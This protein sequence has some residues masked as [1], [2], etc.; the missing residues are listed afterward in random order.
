MTSPLVWVS[1]LKVVIITVVRVLIALL[2][3]AVTALAVGEWLGWSFLR[4]PMET[5]LQDKLQ[6]PVRLAE[7]FKLQLLGKVRL[8]VGGLWIAA[9]KGF[10]VPYLVDAKELTL[11]LAYDDIWDFTHH[12][13]LHIPVL[14]VN[15]IAVQLVRHADGQ[16]TWQFS[17]NR[18]KAK[19]PALPIIDTLQLRQGT[20]LLR[21]PITQTDIN[22]SFETEEGAA[23]RAPVSR[24]KAKGMLRQYAIAG[25]ITTAGFLSVVNAKENTLLKSLGWV[26]YGGVRVDFDGMLSDL[27]GKLNIHGQV[28]VKGPSLAVLGVLAKASLPTTGSFS[29]QGAVEKSGKVWQ[30]NISQATIGSSRLSGNFRYDRSEKVPV[31]TGQVRGQ[32]CMLADLAPAFGARTPEGKLLKPPA[33]RIMPNRILN[34][35]ALKKMDAQ[36]D[37][38]LDYVDLGKAFSQPIAPYKATLI[39]AQGKLTLANIVAQTAKGQVKGQFSVDT[40]PEL[41]LWQADLAWDGI[42]LE[43]WIKVVNRRATARKKKTQVKQPP[44]MTGTLYGKAHLT[45]KGRSTAQLFSAL[46][47]EVSAYIRQGSISHLV[48]EGLGLDIAQG[49]SL[50]RHDKP[51]VMDCAVVN[52]SASNGVLTPKVALIDTPVTLVLSDGKINLNNERLALR[53]VAKPKN[54]SP[55]TLRT[56]I[57]VNGTFLKP[58]VTIEKGPIVLRVIAAI[59]LGAINPLAAIVPMLDLGSKTPTTDSCKQTIL[60]L[61]QEA[62]VRKNKHGNRK[63]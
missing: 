52:M 14:T 38:N 53:V 46:D 30:A 12:L 49:L 58:V 10:A 54:F 23:N 27:F 17:P 59:L 39:L 16:A 19:P 15:T 21:D 40:Q 45:G 18:N 9:P 26:E 34:L 2:L 55:F 1:Y 11:Q 60:V 13:P 37:I 3:I 31:L 63:Q 7:P 35:P 8:Q 28:K 24:V 33:G 4:Q 20:L 22:A 41:P 48:I 32:R 51:L 36:L 61:Q 44:Y 25:Q 43:Q 47:G 50:W 6:R 42:Q 29:M 57:H 56:P 5:F 62:A